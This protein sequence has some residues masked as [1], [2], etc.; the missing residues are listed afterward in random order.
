MSAKKPSKWLKLF[1]EFIQDLRISSKEVS[2]ADERG[3]K[4]VLWDSQHRFLQ[5]LAD[6]LDQGIR[7]FICLKSRQ[8]GITTVSLAIDCFWMAMNPNTIGALVCDTEKNRDVNRATIKRYIASFP[9][10][11]FG[12]QFNLVTDNRTQLIFSNGSRLDL[13]VAGTKKKSSAWGEGVGY[14]YCHLTEIGSFGDSKG[15][16][17]FE[18]SF[19][20]KN[21]NRLFIYEST[22]KGLNHWWAKWL[23]AK[24]RPFDQ[25]PIFIGWWSSP[26]NSIERSDPRYEQYSFAPNA[27]EREL[28]NAVAELYAHRVTR[29]QLAWIR[30][31]ESNVDLSEDA[32]MFEQNQPWTEQQAFVT[33]GY[34]FFQ[35]RLISKL[36]KEIDEAP[37]KEASEGIQN[38]Y[39]F[40]GY[41]Y[42]IGNSFFEMKLIKVEDQEDIDRV[43]LKIWEEPVEGARYTLGCDPAWGRSALKDRSAICV[44]RCFSDCIVQVAEYASHDVDVKQFAWI[45]AHLA[46]AYED[47][48][49][50]VEITGPG[51]MIITEWEH[52]QAQLHSEFYQNAVRDKNWEWALG[53]ARFYLYHRSDSVGGKGYA[54]NFEMT[55]RTKREVMFQY[56]GA[57]MTKELRIRSRYLL[58]EMSNVVQDG[59]DISAPQTRDGGGKDDRVIAA[60]LGCRAWI[61]WRRP[62]MLAYGLSYDR[63]MDD[64]RG[65]STLQAKTYNGLVARFLNYSRQLAENP[66]EEE[67]WRSQRGLR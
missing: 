54:K 14:S 64:E 4:L 26:M 5:G 47:C 19:A 22:A 48:N 23:A 45:I 58:E 7:I 67:D 9:Q 24:D 27:E 2:S 29:E 33:T 50:N 56:R 37:I 63:V 49:M 20:Q 25:K 44:W 10:G 16:A 34:S 51:R 66:P 13:L 57:F 41:Y 38:D 35:T 36:M 43:E 18:E 46:G 55:W 1:E 8:L 52:L 59:D 53:Q 62:E 61:D 3:T 40:A 31:K 17:S 21:P 30:W 12:D 32:D 28:I 6:G 39:I 65:T 60:A 15:L 11:Y 42:E